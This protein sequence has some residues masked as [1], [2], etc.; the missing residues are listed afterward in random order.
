[1]SIISSNMELFIRVIL[2]TIHNETTQVKK[3]QLGKFT[4]FCTSV[5]FVIIMTFRLYA[6]NNP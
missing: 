1:M 3:F 4:I 5:F 6:I 2:N